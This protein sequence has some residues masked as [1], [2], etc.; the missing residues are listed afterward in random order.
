MLHI[1]TK[2]EE[3]GLEWSSSAKLSHT[4]MSGFFSRAT[5]M[6]LPLRNAPSFPQRSTGRFLS[7]SKPCIKLAPVLQEQ[8]SSAD[9]ANPYSFGVEALCSSAPCC[10]T[11]YITKKAYAAA[12]QA[13]FALHT[14]VLLQVYPAK[15]LNSMTQSPQAGDLVLTR[16]CGICHS[17]QH[18]MRFPDVC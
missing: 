11:D 15:L 12:G 17:G 9:C 2:A 16:I 10:T 3:L 13:A 18:Q 8:L 4:W 14:M 5:L 7:P 6:R 1:L